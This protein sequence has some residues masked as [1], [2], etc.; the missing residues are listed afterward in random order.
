MKRIYIVEGSTGA[1]LDRYSWLA[2]AFTDELKA[3][4]FAEMLNCAAKGLFDALDAAGISI[5]DMDDPENS[6]IIDR[7]P[8]LKKDEQ[9]S[10]DDI[11]TFYIVR[12]CELE[13]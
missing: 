3:K 9:F 1:Y 12:T 13:V 8:D 2:K 5:Y 4:E 7:F 6:Y 10:M 11:A